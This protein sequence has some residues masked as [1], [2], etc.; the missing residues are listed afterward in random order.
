M[1]VERFA[2]FISEQVR[3]EQG[4]PLKEAKKD[5]PHKDMEDNGFWH[6]HT[7]PEGHHIYASDET[8]RAVN[9][10]LEQRLRDEVF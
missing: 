9:G 4:L 1:S 2:K 7:T 10:E 5:N 3:K 8:G 6:A